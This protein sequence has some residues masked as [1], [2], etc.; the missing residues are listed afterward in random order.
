M[1]P[2][3]C[4]PAVCCA[5][6]ADSNALNCSDSCATR[7]SPS[8]FSRRAA[9]ALRAPSSCSICCWMSAMPFSA[10]SSWS[11]C[12]ARSPRIAPPCSSNCIVRSLSAS[13]STRAMPD[14]TSSSVMRRVFELIASSCRLLARSSSLS[15]TFEL[16]SSERSAASCASRRSSAASARSADAAPM[17]LRPDVSVA[18]C[19]HAVWWLL[20]ISF[21]LASAL[22]AS[23]S[24]LDRI[25][26]LV[27][28]SFSRMS[29][30][31]VGSAARKASNA[32][33][34]SSRLPNFWPVSPVS[35]SCD[36][37]SLQRLTSTSVRSLRRSDALASM[38]SISGRNTLTLSS[39]VA[40]AWPESANMFCSSSRR[41]SSSCSCFRSLSFA[42]TMDLC[43]LTGSTFD[44]ETGR[45]SSDI[46]DAFDICLE[47]SQ[48]AGPFPSMS[49]SF[50]CNTLLQ[51]L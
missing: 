41:M 5:T 2:L 9:A 1:R 20:L 44:C 49:A 7:L 51:G 30:F 48:G 15:R 19:S 38:R 12:A 28:S 32:D 3:V 34:R 8:S 36:S 11:R 27:P 50:D 43:R 23:L 4:S 31:Q 33:M 26:R 42:S 25:S 35:S 29:A 13:M 10:P 17:S 39:A 21:S 37:L 14:F 40:S 45:T 6:C 24:V 18:S 46:W 16:T 47:R 22:E